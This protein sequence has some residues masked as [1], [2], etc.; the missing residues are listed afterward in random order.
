MSYSIESGHSHTCACGVEYSDSDGSACHGICEHDGCDELV[1]NYQ[2]TQ[3]IPHQFGYCH[4]HFIERLQ[5]DKAFFEIFRQHGKKLVSATFQN[6]E[7]IF[8]WFDLL[9]DFNS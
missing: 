2:F 1:E 5:D 3:S 6:K 8:E 7:E 4:D 9:E